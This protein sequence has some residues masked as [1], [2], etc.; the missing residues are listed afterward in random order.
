MYLVEE[1]VKRDD[2]KVFKNFHRN[3]MIPKTLK[4]TEKRQKIIKWVKKT[5]IKKKIFRK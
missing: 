2:K 3:Q 4:R 1:K 5:K